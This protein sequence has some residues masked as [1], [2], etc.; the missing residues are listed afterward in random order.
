MLTDIQKQSHA[1]AFAQDKTTKWY[2]LI[3]DFAPIHSQ[4]HAD[5]NILSLNRDIHVIGYNNVLVNSI[6]V[7]FFHWV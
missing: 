5:V 6:H 1:D 2:W 4:M 3:C 7:T